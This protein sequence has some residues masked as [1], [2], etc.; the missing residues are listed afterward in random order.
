MSAP[1]PRARRAAGLALATA[2]VAAGLASAG[3]AHALEGPGAPAGHHTSV[4]GLTLGDG[5][6][7][8]G[9]SGTLID[10]YWLATAA[11][12]FGGTPGGAVRAGEPAVKATAAFAGG[13]TVR[14]AELAPRADRDLVLARLAT[15]VTDVPTVRTGSAAPAVGAELTA[16]GH[17]R[18]RTQWVPGRAHTGTFTVNASDAGTLSVTG[19]GG[20]VLCKGDTGGPLLTAAGEL[21]GVN[22]RSWQGGCLGADPAETRTG[23]VA[24]RTDDLADWIARTTAPRRSASSHEAGGTGRVRWADFDGDRRPDYVTV[25]DNGEVKVWLNHGGDPAGAGGWAAVGR[26]ATGTTTDRSRVRLADFDG[27]GRFDYLVVNPN[28]SVDVWL[29][30]G[31]DVSG[32]DGWQAVGQVASGVTTDQSKVRFADWDGDGRTDYLAL[33]DSGAV[34]VYLNRGGD[35]VAPWQH[36]GRVATGVTSDRSRVRFAD[37]DGDGKADYLVIKASGAVD[38]YLNRGGDVVAN[39]WKA[40]GRIA[41]GVTTDHHRVQFADFTGDTHADYVL[42]GSGTDSGATVYG[43]NGGDPAGAAGWTNVG[44]V[45]TGA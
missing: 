18:T 27:D 6:N 3:T 31:G 21:V 34:D 7:T 24:T 42:G 10:S 12:C 20:D 8:R 35:R 19:K 38:L 22:T 44:K 4:V 11:S 17:G 25:A 41:T 9:C 15:P 43:W 40:V 1:H 45:A 26:V 30:R 39:G 16:V 36:V 33:G 5:E 13:R 32:P 23:A 14:I 37:V 28:G 2:T 29:N